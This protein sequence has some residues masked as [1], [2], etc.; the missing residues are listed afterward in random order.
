MRG[1]LQSLVVAVVRHTLLTPCD[2][3]IC[4]GR[5]AR[6]SPPASTFRDTMLCSQLSC[7][8]RGGLHDQ[9]RPSHTRPRPSLPVV[10]AQCSVEDECRA[11]AARLVVLLVAGV[12]YHGVT[13]ASGHVSIWWAA[14]RG[15]GYMD[16]AQALARP[17]RGGSAPA[18][19][20]HPGRCRSMS[21]KAGELVVGAA[22]LRE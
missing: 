1:G 6:T 7:H 12:Q 3:S 5:L 15:N 21:H 22:A 9:H 17:L 8:R 19:C 20:L 11:R 14:A 16:A 10:L 2:E 18:L 13:I 4:G